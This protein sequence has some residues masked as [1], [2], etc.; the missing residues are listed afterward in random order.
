MLTSTERHS[1][2]AAA[3]RPEMT[4]V[5]GRSQRLL[6]LAPAGVPCGVGDFTG[7]L[8]AALQRV[9]GEDA[10]AAL[11]FERCRGLAGGLGRALDKADALV[12]NL[13][14]VAWKRLLIEPLAA[15][16]YARARGRRTVVVLHEWG[17]LH[18]LRRATYR[19][20]LAFADR[21][22]MV[23]PQVRAELAADPI[24]GRLARRVRLIPLPPNLV[25][26]AATRPTALSERL[27]AARSDG[28]LVLG[29]FGSIYPGKQPEAL[30]DVA[31]ELK[32]R[33]ERPLLAFIGFFVRGTDG[34]EERF[35][36]RVAD[37][38]L[39][40]DVVVTGRVGP[41]E[42]LYGLFDSVDLFAY[43]FAEGLTARRASVMAALQAGRPVVTS[44]PASPDEFAA[45]PRLARLVEAGALS[46]VPTGA[47]AATFAEAL[48]QARRR[49]LPAVEVDV[50]AWWDETAR[51]LTAMLD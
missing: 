31:A 6:L 39:D 11:P 28:R 12:L 32:R 1:G 46:F 13:P 20:L 45:N 51:A 44:A 7:R 9:G 24:V 33:G 26:P 48:V 36:A 3:A 49:P 25:R 10:A 23:S 21:I 15:L 34:I 37:L 47:D 43:D 22:A 41:A 16:A 14:L 42:E 4:A 2:L 50:E 40:D 35:R 38:G 30:L 5:A 17:G 8:T 29:T 18:P 27:A 19:P